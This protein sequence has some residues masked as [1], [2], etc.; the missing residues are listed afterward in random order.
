[1]SVFHAISQYYDI[2]YDSKQYEK[3]ASCIDEAVRR[4][5]PIHAHAT[6]LDIGCGTG[7]H[8]IPFAAKGYELTGVDVSPQML[9]RAKEKL[10]E[11]RIPANLI[12]A[13]ARTLDIGKTYDVVVSLFH[14]L[15]YQ[16]TNEDVLQFFHTIKT[17]LKPHGVAV[18]DCWY[19]PGV[20][21]DVPEVRSSIYKAR[22][23][24][25]HRTKEPTL[26]VHTNTVKVHHTLTV[27]TDSG[28]RVGEIEETH[29][30]RYFFYPE[31]CMFL[32]QAGMRL[33]DWGV[34]GKDGLII[35]RDTSWDAYF[36]VARQ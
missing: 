28:D 23:N 25:I 34:F 5:A 26:F 31:L 21:Q 8:L 35:P 7:S 15:S 2:L 9:A 30:M 4:H 3:E 22:G 18:F 13:D 1:M 14:V 10:L 33:L 24:V 11:S 6:L 20:L 29:T 36:I 32:E 16:T 27:Q 19:G 17:H 12:E